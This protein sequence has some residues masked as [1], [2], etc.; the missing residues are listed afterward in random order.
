V[1][2][3]ECREKYL[4]LNDKENLASQALKEAKD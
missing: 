2:E 4:L 3:T 1:F